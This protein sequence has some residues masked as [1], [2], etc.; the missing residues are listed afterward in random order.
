M[1]STLKFKQG[2]ADV[3]LDARGET[4][5]FEKPDARGA[6]MARLAEVMDTALQVPVAPA[7]ARSEVPPEERLSEVLKRE[8]PGVGLCLGRYD[9]ESGVIQALLAVGRQEASAS[10]RGQVE[11]T[12]GVALPPERIVVVP[13]ET[14]ALLQRLADLGFIT[15]RADAARTLLDTGS[16][17]PPPPP[18]H[19]VR[20]KR[21]QQVLE[22]AQRN[23]RMAEVLAGGGF[24]DE[25]AATAR[26]AICQAAG[27]LFLF[28]PGVPLDQPL[29]PLT[30][31][32]VA[33][34]RQ[35]AGV[36]RELVATV[37]MAH[38]DV[39]AEPAATLG[40]AKAFV[41]AC[42]ERLDRQQIRC[43]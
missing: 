29:E 37:Q 42:A 13:P 39:A 3:V 28:A 11:K 10:L 27:T 38:L 15:I 1:L 19:A 9:E 36:T 23:L 24:A 30:E 41:D 16:D 7:V 6:F 4:E 21:A 12:H 34:I 25:A 22:A 17:T 20:C 8:N 35:D 5:A 26:Q 18:D 2:L 40:Q 43:S 14:R 31:A 33:A 32:M